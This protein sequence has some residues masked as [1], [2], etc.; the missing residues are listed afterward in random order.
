MA[1]EST[2]PTPAPIRP[3]VDEGL[4]AWAKVV[5]SALAAQHGVELIG[6]SGASVHFAFRGQSFAVQIHR[7]T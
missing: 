5:Q 4:A 2:E 6:R 7:V 1:D 3:E